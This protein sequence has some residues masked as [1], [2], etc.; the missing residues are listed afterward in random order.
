M[1][2][3]K[4]S[5]N[6]VSERSQTYFHSTDIYRVEYRSGTGSLDTKTMH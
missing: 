5:L 3:G 6:Y 4:K 2:E 1:K